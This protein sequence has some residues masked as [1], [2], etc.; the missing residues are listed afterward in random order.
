MV[1][2]GCRPAI[3]MGIGGTAVRKISRGPAAAELRAATDFPVDTLDDRDAPERAGG[4]PVSPVPPQ[5]A[6]ARANTVLHHRSRRIR[7]L[8]LRPPDRF[9]VRALQPITMLQTK[10]A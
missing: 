2:E 4:Y 10:H 8:T 9:R 3:E 7:R 5:A 6:S 1:G